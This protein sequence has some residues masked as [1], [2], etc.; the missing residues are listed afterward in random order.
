M[1]ERE[2]GSEWVSGWVREGG[3][4]RRKRKTVNSETHVC[5]AMEN[6]L[7]HKALCMLH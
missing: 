6:E 4:E 7:K 5:C 2:R 3:R 1:C